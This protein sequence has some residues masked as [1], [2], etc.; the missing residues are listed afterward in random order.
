MRTGGE[1]TSGLSDGALWQKS[2]VTESPEDEAARFLDLAGFADGT[3]D[4]DDRE[5]VAEWLSRDPVAAADVAA[6][7]G[8]AAAASEPDAAP[9]PVTARAC[10]LVGGDA[11]RRGDVVP[12][13]PRR[14]PG[15]QFFALAQWGSLA[16]ALVVAGWLGFTLGMNTSQ[17]FDAAGQ[18]GSDSFL[19]ELLD[20]S[21]GFM[22]DLTG[23][24]QT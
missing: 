6:A 3:L 8:F 4:P 19:H 12:L 2:S 22:S 20:P 10:A 11:R 18:I 15:L 14:R 1:D 9:E 21:T 17:S 13:P 7:R 23:G 24:S 5:R 16:A